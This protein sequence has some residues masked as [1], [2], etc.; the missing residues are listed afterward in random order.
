MII[1]GIYLDGKTS[2]RVKARL[3][4]LQ[5]QSSDLHILHVDRHPEK[6]PLELSKAKIES[7]VGNTPR[8]I[9]FGDDQLFISDD[10]DSIDKLIKLHVPSFWAG[11]IHKLE[12]NLALVLTATLMTISLLWLAVTSGI[13]KS[14]EYIAY[15]LPNFTSDHFGSTLSLL[16]ETM[17]DPSQLPDEKQANIQ[18]LAKPF[19]QK[20][21]N[22]NAKLVF[23]S[24]NSANAFALPDGHI[25][26][27][28]DIVHL[29]KNN[30]ELMA[31]LF[32]EIGHLKYKHLLRRALQDSMITLALIL[33][34]GDLDTIDLVT[35][36]PTLL[37]DLHYSKEFESEADYFAIQQLHDNNMPVDA[38]ASIMKGLEE[39]FEN[40]TTEN[41]ENDSDQ[42][43]N[44]TEFLSTHPATQQ[45]IDMVENFKKGLTHK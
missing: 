24:S 13:P 26:F 43:S 44:L 32:H 25:V 8:E 31:I 5:G 18:A 33:L 20:D 6:L 39:Q 45:R 11:V 23:R 41:T 42:T 35:G 7:R 14:A 4:V 3:D 34:T 21:P 40:S 29:A 2:K 17:F 22:L 15:Q 19:L 12:S 16:D 37:L 9:A 1:N 30:Q 27:T 38:F 28:D 36:L 10:H